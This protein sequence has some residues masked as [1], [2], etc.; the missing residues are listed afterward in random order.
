[1]E[2][3]ITIEE[4]RLCSSSDASTYEKRFLQKQ[5][6]ISAWALTRTFDGINSRQ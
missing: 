1:M 6:T 2:T 3:E 5:N 4:D